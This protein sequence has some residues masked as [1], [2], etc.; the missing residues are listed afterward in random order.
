M[1]EKM[2][3]PPACIN[4]PALLRG[5]VSAEFSAVLA[6]QL[7]IIALL[8]V[9]FGGIMA[10]SALRSQYI[11]A[12]DSVS[13]VSEIAREVWLDGAGAQKRVQ[14]RIPPIANLQRSYIDNNTVDIYLETF[15]DIS[16]AVPFGISGSWP[17]APG[18]SFVDVI[19]NG[20]SVIVRPA[21]YVSANATTLYYEINKSAG[22]YS[23][24]ALHVSNSMDVPYNIT[25]GPN[26]CSSSIACIVSPA[27]MQQIGPGAYYDFIIGVNATGYAAGLYSGYVNLTIVPNSTGYP[28]GTY[29]IP[30]T[31]RAYN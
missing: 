4:R 25:A 1:D 20:T 26:P 19:H 18:D 12:R 23:S 6:L 10:Q 28:N 9:I 15:G 24:L 3:S 30:I 29:T 7:L 13:G 21:L 27:A 22:N 14:V 2:P 8:M 31:A 11:V 17:S 5:Q 16:F